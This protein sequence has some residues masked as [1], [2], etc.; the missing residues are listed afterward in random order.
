MTPSEITF[1]DGTD[2]KIMDCEW[3]ESRDQEYFD[4]YGLI[5]QRTTR[6]GGD[7]CQR[8]GMFY[9]ALHVLGYSRANEYGQVLKSLEVESNCYVRH[10][11]KFMWYSDK[12]RLSRDQATPLVITMGALGFKDRLVKFMIAHI[13]RFGFM[14][15]TR[16]NGIWRNRNE[17]LIKAPITK[18]WNYSW[19]VPDFCGPEF[20][21]LYIRGLKLWYL[22]PILFLSDLE[23]LAGSIIRRFNSDKDVLN[24]V[25][26]CHQAKTR[27]PT[28]F[29]WLANIFN[30]SDDLLYKMGLYFDGE[31]PPFMVRLYK[32]II[33]EL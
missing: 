15:N 27:Y 10:P 24:H 8:M 17:H 29:I 3:F 26:I 14:T 12:D 22:Y 25:M 1:I 32:S 23:T 16:R 20:F 19:K 18:G 9:Y 11:D 28:P 7:T 31:D 33:R 30:D 5:V 2:V 4:R 13:L 6:D 21:G